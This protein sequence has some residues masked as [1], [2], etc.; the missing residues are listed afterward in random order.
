MNE[1]ISNQIP[2]SQTIVDFWHLILDQDLKLIVQ[3]EVAQV[4]QKNKSYTI[5]NK[6]AAG[7]LK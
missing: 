6:I 2:L 4:S 7:Y 3:L 5:L 1:W